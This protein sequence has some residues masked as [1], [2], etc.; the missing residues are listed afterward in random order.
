MV[1]PDVP[2]SPLSRLL[3]LG[4]L[5]CTPGCAAR[6]R[7][8]LGVGPGLAVVDV[9]Q[10]PLTWHP[11]VA[12]STHRSPP[13]GQL[14]GLATHSSLL[15]HDFEAIGDGYRWYFEGPP[16]DD[17]LRVA[18]LWPGMVLMPFIGSQLSGGVGVHIQVW[19]GEVLPFAE[20]GMQGALWLNPSAEAHRFDLQAGPWMG[21][22]VAF[23]SGLSLRFQSALETMLL[24]TLWEGERVLVPQARVLV[25]FELF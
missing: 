20:G 7:H 4:L 1:A 12:L 23:D 2:A 14:L 25:S 24:A 21:A 13:A 15:V 9:P 18:L 8:Q 3:A 17:L 22:G 11:G 5:A 10:Q 19:A 16:E 6:G